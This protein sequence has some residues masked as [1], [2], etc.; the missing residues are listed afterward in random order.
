MSCLVPPPLGR[1][2][3]LWGATL[4]GGNT[5]YGRASRIPHPNPL[6]KGEGVKRPFAALSIAFFLSQSPKKD[7]KKIV[8][9]FYA[10]DV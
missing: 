8:V 2:P 7:T 6:P 9:G 5:S 4:G 1:T 3:R 10:S